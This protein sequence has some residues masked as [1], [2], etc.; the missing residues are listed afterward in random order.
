MVPDLTDENAS[1]PDAP[2]VVEYLDEDRGFHALLTDEV[3]RERPYVLTWSDLG[4]N[5]W[6]ERYVRLD[7]AL[8]RLALLVRAAGSERFFTNEAYLFAFNWDHFTDRQ[9][10]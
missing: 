1:D 9:L 8:A 4:P 2:V 7:Q 5:G 6:V 3:G 10:H